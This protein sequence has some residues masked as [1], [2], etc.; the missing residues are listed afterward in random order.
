MTDQYMDHFAPVHEP[1]VLVVPTREY[2]LVLGLP[3]FETRKLEIIWATSR[4]TSLKTPSGQ[5]EARRAGM[6]VQWYKGRD[7]ESTNVWLPDIGR[8]MPTIN[9]MS[10][11]LVDRDGKPTESGKDSA[12]PEIEIL[13]PT[14]FNHLLASHETIETFTLRIGECS[15]LLGATTEVTTLENPGEIET[16]N[17]KRRTSDHGAVV[18]VLAEEYPQ[19]LE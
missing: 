10:E 16:I 5:G 19:T 13:G 3:G 1:E 9:S 15:G 14:A 18:V 6:M 8:C 2:N 7:D 4:I 12:T 17:S 11:I